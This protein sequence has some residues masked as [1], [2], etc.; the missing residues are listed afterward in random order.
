MAEFY[1]NSTYKS[2]MLVLILLFWL[3]LKA[4]VI[5]VKCIFLMS[6]IFKMNKE[7]SFTMP[8]PSTM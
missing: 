7:C 1:S 6:I 4:F 5:L 3:N 2:N 8:L